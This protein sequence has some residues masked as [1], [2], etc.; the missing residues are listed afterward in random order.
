MVI[1]VA[2]ILANEWLDGFIAKQNKIQYIEYHQMNLQNRKRFT[3]L[4]NK[5]MAAG[6]KDRDKG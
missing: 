2:T 1:K 4:E 3:G 6:R 5:L